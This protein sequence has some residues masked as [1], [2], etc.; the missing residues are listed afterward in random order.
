[1]T[2]FKVNSDDQAVRGLQKDNKAPVI[3]G[4]VLPVKASNPVQKAPENI[5]LN[6]TTADR[7]NTEPH[8]PQRRQIDRRT[9]DS[10]VLLD[11]RNQHDRRTKAEPSDEADKNSEVT[12]LHGIDELV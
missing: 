4:P 10:T 7:K 2:S 12:T 5:I 11:T 8:T 6:T 9:T 3:S 1:M